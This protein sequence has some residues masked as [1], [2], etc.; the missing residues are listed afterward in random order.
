VT[1]PRKILFLGASS[2]LAQHLIKIIN[3]QEYEVVGLARK[4]TVHKEKN[5]IKVIEREALE[6]YYFEAVINFVTDYD[7]NKDIT[8]LRT[9]NHDYP[10]SIVQVAKSK[11]VINCSTCLPKDHS[12]YSLTKHELEESLKSLVESKKIK[13]INLK[14][15]NMYG[16]YYPHQNFISSAI[17]SVINNKPFTVNDPNQSRD[18]IHVEDL[19]RAILVVLKNLDQLNSYEEIEIGSGEATALKD[20][21]SIIQSAPEVIT[22]HNPKV[23]EKHAMRANITK[24]CSLGWKPQLSLEEGLSKVLKSKSE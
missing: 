11:A 22:T 7:N 8:E 15:H 21:I 12:G 18:F 23:D 9:V 14:I 20:I 1:I 10:L 2:Y 13:I 24:I 19:A 3:I 6:S 16:P 4:D 5:N 17:H